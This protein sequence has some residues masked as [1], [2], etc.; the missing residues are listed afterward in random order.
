M[1]HEQSLKNRNALLR[2][3]KRMAASAFLSTV[4]ALFLFNWVLE[5]VNP[6]EVLF[7]TGMTSIR[8]NN[9]VSK[10]PKIMDSKEDPEILML[11]SSISLYPMARLDDLQEKGRTRWDETYVRY[12]CCPYQ[13]ADYLKSGLEKSLGRKLSLTNASVVA[14]IISDQYLILDKYLKSG[15]KPEIV[16]L[17]TAPRDFMLNNSSKIGK[18][19]TFEV[20]ADH[21]N[22]YDVVSSN[23]DFKNLFEFALGQV[24]TFYNSRRDYKG[25]AQAATNRLAGRTKIAGAED[26]SPKAVNIFEVDKFWEAEAIYKQP[27]NKLRQLEYYRDSYQPLDTN[28]MVNQTRYFKKL[29]TLTQK[30]GIKLIVIDT[31]LPQIHYDLIPEKGLDQYRKTLAEVCANHG[32]HL[33]TPGQEKVYDLNDFEDVSH[34]NLQ[35]GEKLC[36]NLFQTLTRDATQAPH[37]STGV[38]LSKSANKAKQL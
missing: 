22:F 13:K 6:L 15:K 8:Q 19:P 4:A 10:L 18:S 5:K 16:L 29:L 34:L 2:L 25:L 3:P 9:M 20:L 7:F 21:Q 24:F 30:H 11:G 26:D 36:Q 14:A 33:L 27:P 12:H 38:S 1:N 28:R 32:A 35:G 23:P 17:F 37:S 31:P